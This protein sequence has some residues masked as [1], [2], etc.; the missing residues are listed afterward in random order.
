MLEESMKDSKRNQLKKDMLLYAVTDRS[1]LDD[2]KTLYGECEKAI[3]GGITLLQ[4]REKTLSTEDFI[5]EGFL[6]KKLC[7]EN[8]IKLIINDDVDVMLA[9]DA[10]GL[11]IGQDDGDVKRIRN[12]I[13]PNKILG[14]S[15]QTVEESIKAI[16]DGADYLGIGAVFS[17]ST[18]LDAVDVS[19]QTLKEIT[20]VSTIPTCAIGGINLDNISELESSGINGCAIVSAIFNSDDVE[21]ATR[22]LRKKCDES[23][24]KYNVGNHIYDL[25]GTLIDSLGI[26][27]NL[28]SSYL[29]DKG[30]VAKV[31]LDEEI[32]NFSLDESAIYLKLNYDLFENKDE[33]K[34]QIINKIYHLY[35]QSIQLKSGVK[36]YLQNIYNNGATLSIA[37][38]SSKSMVNAVLKN[39]GIDKLFSIIKTEEEVGISKTKSSLIYDE[40]LKELDVEKNDVV[41]FEDSY[42]AIKTLKSND[43]YSIGVYDKHSVDDVSDICD[44]FIKDFKEL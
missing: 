44:Y 12:I 28:A 4:L 13:G 15:S 2:T 23:F 35:S 22:I 34:E 1:W 42:A 8:N 6:I 27:K 39:N 9:L 32:S 29:M 37:S 38:A 16:N 19:L 41:I 24:Y 20:R 5:K 17:T 36:S 21:K 7:H 11:H 33:I 43:Y 10:D 18:K 14:V 3:K 30:I 31:N 40:I 25:D 26:W